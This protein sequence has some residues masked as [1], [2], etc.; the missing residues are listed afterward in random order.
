MTRTR[1]PANHT[2]MEAQ[3]GRA[4]IHFEKE[5]MGRGPLDTR[6]YLLGDLILVRLKGVLT[7]AERKLSESQSDRSAYLL[8]QVRNE[9]LTSGRHLLEAVIQ[10]IVGVPIQ[11]VHTDISTKTGERI[12]VFSLARAP[13][14]KGG[15]S[16]GPAQ[17]SVDGDHEYASGSAAAAA[18]LRSD[19]RQ[20]DKSHRSSMT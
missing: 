1:V 8:K 2:D 6:A 7:P 18:P 19:V 16:S 5:F 12:F 10:D 11:S 20:L 13:S 17:D 3:I 14:F 9:L 4:V 15:K